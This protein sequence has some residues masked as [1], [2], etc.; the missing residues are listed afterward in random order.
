FGAAL[1]PALLALEGDRGARSVL[2]SLGKA[3]AHVDVDDARPADVDTPDAL[4]VVERE[5][6]RRA[7][8]ER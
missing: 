1:F 3:L 4:R 6:A 7:L 8:G 2:D 5:L